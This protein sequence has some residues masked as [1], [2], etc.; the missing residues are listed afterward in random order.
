M[1]ENGDASLPGRRDFIVQAAGAFVGVGSTLALWPFIHQMN[2]NDGTPP[3]QVTE[4]DLHP[5][6]PGQMISVAWRGMPILIRHRTRQEVHLA[7]STPL[8]DLP[9]RF[10][11]NEALPAKSL[12]SDANRTRE[13]H[14][15]WLVVVGLC[16]HMGCVLT[17]QQPP[18]TLATGEGWF[19]PC[20]AARF[21]LS[22]RVRSGPART[23]LA[24][25]PYEFLT[26][27]K[28]RIG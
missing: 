12:A 14:D 10:A 17:S 6:Q 26:A 24:V 16:T 9:D 27:T 8:S 7:R 5:I 25:P 21:D 15:N 23:N 3:P 2:P 19:C 28:I 11:R 13:G 1:T 18:A 22:G 4:V 20:H